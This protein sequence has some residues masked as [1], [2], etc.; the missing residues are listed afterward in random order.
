MRVK[1]LRVFY[2]G[3]LAFNQGHDDIKTIRRK[4]LE[5][6]LYS[7]GLLLAEHWNDLQKKLEKSQN[8]RVSRK[9]L[10]LPLKIV[11][12]HELGIIDALQTRFKQNQID[13]F[14]NQLANLI[15]LITS[16][17]PKNH[18]SIVEYITS[19][20]SDTSADLLSA[21]NISIIKKELERF[22]LT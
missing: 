6:F 3:F 12:L 20:S 16:E 4:F 19:L 21:D 22:Q 5:L 14:H 17:N 8:K 1:F 18:H 13:G 10:S 7:Q 11:M 9:K 15:C 2:N